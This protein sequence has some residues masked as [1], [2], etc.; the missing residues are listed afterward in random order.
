[1]IP[2]NAA[3][4]GAY[5][6]SRLQ[7]AVAGGYLLASALTVIWA[8]S[9]VSHGRVWLGL[10]LAAFLLRRLWLGSGACDKDLAAHHRQEPSG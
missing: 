6:L 8:F 3:P 7:A 4:A 1:M 2:S 9:P 10:L 5:L